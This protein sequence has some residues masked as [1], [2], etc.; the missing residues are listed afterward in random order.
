MNIL[1]FGA[2]FCNVQLAIFGGTVSSAV[3]SRVGT[4]E[5]PILGNSFANQAY[6][7]PLCDSCE[8]ELFCC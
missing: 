8:P 6:N 3:L 1:I 4:V 5:L 7:S 2:A